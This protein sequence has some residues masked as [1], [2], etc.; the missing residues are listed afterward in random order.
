VLCYRD[1]TFCI[2]PNCTCGA[3]RKLTP[4]IE[5]AAEKWWGGKGAPIATA[6][7]CKMGDPAP[8]RPDEH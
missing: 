8:E 3:G 2:N 7:L 1:M 5:R 6:D 4:E